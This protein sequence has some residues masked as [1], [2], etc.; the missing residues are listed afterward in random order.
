MTEAYEDG[1]PFVLVDEAR[2]WIADVVGNAEDVEDA[3][4]ADVMEYVRRHYD[5]GVI[6]LAAN[7]YDQYGY[8]TIAATLR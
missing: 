8:G 6:A 1:A 5:G 4:D 2:A 7:T 3:S